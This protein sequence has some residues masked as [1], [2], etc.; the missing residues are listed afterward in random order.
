M[1]LI[2]EKPS[3][4]ASPSVN[5]SASFPTWIG[6]GFNPDLHGERL[7]THHLNNGTA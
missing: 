1:I 4:S 2:R 5:L 7:V 3:T 6:L